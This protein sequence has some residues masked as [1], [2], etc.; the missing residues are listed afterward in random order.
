M[1][2]SRRGLLALLCCVSVNTASVSSYHYMVSE[3][4]AAMSLQNLRAPDPLK[5]SGG[6][7]AATIRKIRSAETDILTEYPDPF[8]GVGLLSGDVHLEVDE[9]MQPVQMPL[10]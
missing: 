5:L 9:T 10:R 7:V 1:I 4:A 6:N 8:E 3:V 2:D